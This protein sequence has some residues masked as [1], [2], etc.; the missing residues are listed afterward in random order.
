MSNQN[1]TT[2][3]MHKPKPCFVVEVKKL[4]QEFIANI[5]SRDGNRNDYWDRLSKLVVDEY[6]YISN[7]GGSR[8]DISERKKLHINLT[9]DVI[10]GILGTKSSCLLV[11]SL[12]EYIATLEHFVN[13]L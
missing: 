4:L 8:Y 1:D 6:Y 9:L 5:K 10:I 2:K 7:V 13:Q 12:D 3:I 11:G